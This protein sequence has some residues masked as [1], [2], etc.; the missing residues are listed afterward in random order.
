MARLSR[1]VIPG[2][3]H[4]LLQR[5]HGGVP[6]FKQEEDCRLYLQTL[7]GLV[8]EHGVALHAYALT[9]EQVLLLAT[10]ASELS[11]ARMMQALGRRFGAAY[12]RRHGRTGA[13]WESRFRTTVI[14]AE[15]HLLDCIRYVEQAPLRVSQK[16][17]L[18]DAVWSSASHHLGRCI[19]PLITEHG[20][21]WQLGNTPF[22]REAAYRSLFEQ[23][24]P[25]S[26][27]HQISHAATKGWVL[28][29]P[30]FVQALEP[31]AGRRLAPLPRGRPKR[32]LHNE[33]ADP[34]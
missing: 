4:L 18:P 15:A 30:S 11:L 24:L 7:G 8:A 32:D 10:P 22:E 29:P 19:D 2:Q 12:N 27:E 31:Q 28:G 9:P 13:L 14:D 25:T 17:G 21:Y 23:S 26:L 6:V 1:L 5:S 3:V 34:N 20:H 33:K 16:D